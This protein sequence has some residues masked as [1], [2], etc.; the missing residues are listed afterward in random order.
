M[1]KSTWL[2]P[3]LFAILILI[4]GLITE[5]RIVI[6]IGSLMFINSTVLE[7]IYWIKD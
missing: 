3:Q 7:A 2:V 6:A 1:T 5:N 4:L